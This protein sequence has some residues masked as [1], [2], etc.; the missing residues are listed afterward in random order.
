MCGI[1][2]SINLKDAFNLNDYSIFEKC[3]NLVSHRGPDAEGI[4]ILN[5]TDGDA[6]NANFN[7][8][9]GHRRLSIIDLSE[10]ANQPLCINNIWLIYNG[11]IFN[12]LE[13]KQELIK[14]GES[15]LTNSD[16]EVII[17]IYKHF[18]TEG[19]NKLNGMWAFILVDLNNQKI[20][21][22][23]DRFSIKP[24][25]YYKDN[26]K[27]YFAS[28]IKQLKLL[29][30]KTEIEE[31]IL[32]DFL[33]QGLLD[34]T[35]NT[36]FKG[37]KRFPPRQNLI[38]DKDFNFHYQEYWKFEKYVIH[39]KAIDETFINLFQD[40][41]K[42]RLRSDVPV[43][44]LLSGGIDSSAIT[45]LANDLLNRNINSFSV[46]SEDKKYSEEKFVDILINNCGI[47]NEKFSFEV[48]HVLKKLE[49]VLQSQDEPFVSFNAIAQNE[50]FALI[51]KHS[52]IKVVLSGQGSDE[53]LLGY[54]RHY[55]FYL[56]QL[57]KE[58]EIFPLSFEMLGSLFNRTI[59]WQFDFSKVKRYSKGFST[60]KKN[61]FKSP[62][63]EK[64]IW[65][66]NNFFDNHIQ[67]IEY[68]SIP[69][70]TRY[71]DRN[72]M[73]HSIETRL[74]F[75]DHR[76]VEFL[77]N[78]PVNY[79]IKNGWTKYLLRKN[80]KQLPDEIKWRR[81]KKGFTVPE[82]K[83]LKNDL[84]EEIISLFSES[85]LSSLGII[86]DTSF[87]AYY[88]SYCNGNPAIHFSEM[89]RFYVAEK[90]LRSINL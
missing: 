88:K 62:F 16:S 86:N 59:L 5:F 46:I 80:V 81:D 66:E 54:M 64:K 58:R 87:L 8:F 13:L 20:I 56:N 34:H 31:E 61:L 79:K 52:D 68:S 6:D 43:A 74:P 25:F 65:N 83:W 51:K 76:L 30:N 19:F 45:L 21:V 27:I 77:I 82:D 75:L 18:G 41:I 49:E 22:S 55:Y 89:S 39:E 35:N 33:N 90:W 69:I 3:I 28:E 47:K 78:C 2:C 37:I 42:I 38:I 40:S 85:K 71:E 26:S 57:L 53:I 1:F 70:L 48:S 14:S 10:E 17:K 67:D 12:Y 11:E 4:K 29:L 24:L 84:K 60:R 9:L 72:S 7:I 32:Y 15:F 73:A 50:I 23:R 36:F 44:S 63:E